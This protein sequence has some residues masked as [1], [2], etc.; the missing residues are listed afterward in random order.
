M[1]LGLTMIDPA[2]IG[3]VGKLDLT[4][5]GGWNKYGSD[6]IVAGSP[7]SSLEVSDTTIGVPA[8]D[9]TILYF[10]LNAPEAGSADR[11][12]TLR[13]NNDSGAKYHV[14]DDTDW[15]Y[16]ITG[17]RATGISFGNA[18]I[19]FGRLMMTYAKIGNYPNPDRRHLIIYG[20]VGTVGNDGI[21]RHKN[22]AAMYAGPT[23][24]SNIRINRISMSMASSATY[25][26]GKIL[27]VYQHRDLDPNLGGHFE[28]IMDRIDD[29][30]GAAV[31]NN[32][33]LLY[34]KKHIVEMIIARKIQYAA[35]S[36]NI[37][38]TFDYLYA[39]EAENQVATRQ[40]NR[41]AS[42]IGNNAVVRHNGSDGSSTQMYNLA[43]V[44]GIGYEIDRITL[45]DPNHDGRY[46]FL[47]Q[48]AYRNASG[49]WLTYMSAVG[50]YDGE[51]P[52]LDARPKRGVLDRRNTG[53]T[54]TKISSIAY[55]GE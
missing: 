36:R 15:T 18:G 34:P 19:L 29:E 47:D 24:T 42:R 20:V 14:R 32:N 25:D 10:Y 17:N 12:T 27:V 5:F 7:R 2:L 39:N 22:I 40:P 52:T 38:R 49:G 23:N 46:A 16:S 51:V 33:F 26:H 35:G 13:I 48:H 44:S 4:Q 53:E 55:G 28:T 37:H 30:A 21:L 11:T 50:M 43:G 1:T 41:L 6:E 9:A 54:A 45:F 31:A 3:D 8:P